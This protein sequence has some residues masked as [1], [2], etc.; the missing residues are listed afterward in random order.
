MTKLEILNLLNEVFVDKSIY[1][2][3]HNKFS[4]IDIVGAGLSFFT[5]SEDSSKSCI[6]YCSFTLIRENKEIMIPDKLAKYFIEEFFEMSKVVSEISK[7]IDSVRKRL[8][9]MNCDNYI[10]DIKLK[11]I[12]ND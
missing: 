2:N 11:K 4:V 9:G 3:P 8:N 12:L 7:D 5:Y 10:R 1:I 6:W